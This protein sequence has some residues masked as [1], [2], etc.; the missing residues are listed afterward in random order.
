VRRAGNSEVADLFRAVNERVVELGAPAL[1]PA[2]LICECP[3][4][5]CMRV[6]RMSLDAFDALRAEP[7][8]YAVVPGHEQPDD[9]GE[10]VGRANGYVLVRFA[11]APAT[12]GL[13]V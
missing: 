8:L 5:T 4:Q 3:D 1:G 7:A 9:E 10:V 6:L 13:V 12:A 11:G 2:D